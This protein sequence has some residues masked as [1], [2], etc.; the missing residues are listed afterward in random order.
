[1]YSQ[2]NEDIIEDEALRLILVTHTKKSPHTVRATRN[3]Y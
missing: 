1:M 2:W 3:S